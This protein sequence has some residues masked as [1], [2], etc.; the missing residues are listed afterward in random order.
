MLS[1]RCEDA[2]GSLQ[3]SPDLT[4]RLVH[5]MS[6]ITRRDSSG[7]LAFSSSMPSQR[8]LAVSSSGASCETG[9]RACQ[10]GGHLLLL[11]QS[12]S[13]YLFSLHGSSRRRGIGMQ[14]DVPGSSCAIHNGVTDARIDGASVIT[15]VQTARNFPTGLPLPSSLLLRRPAPSG[16]RVIAGYKGGS[17]IYIVLIMSLAVEMKVESM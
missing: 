8:Q 12:Y 9:R 7:S 6:R 5:S 16:I 13:Q 10:C 17:L 4:R 3:S 14:P 15:A 2:L 11:S 1:W